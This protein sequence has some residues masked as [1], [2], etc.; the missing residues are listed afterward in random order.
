MGKSLKK[1]VVISGFNIHDDNRGCSALS[2]GAVNFLYKK[3]F[4]SKDHEFINLFPVRKFWKKRNR[5]IYTDTITVDSIEFK[6]KT[7]KYFI[8]EYYL[9]KM[10]S[11]RMPF[12]NFGKVL[13]SILKVAAINGGDGFSDIYGTS[14][15]RHRL[16]ETEIA[17]KQ[18]LPLIILPQTIGPF[19]EQSNYQKAKEILK[20]ADRIFIRDDCF[21]DELRRMDVE[22]ELTKDLSAFMPPDPIDI[23]IAGDSIGINVSGLAYSNNFSGLVGQFEFYPILIDKLIGYYT[24]LGRKVYLIP[25]S[26]NCN[27]PDL[28]NDDFVAC[29]TVADKWKH[30]SNVIFVKKDITAPQIKY[31]ISKMSFFIGTRMHANFAAIYTGVPL[32]GLAYSYKFEG[33]FNANG[34]DGEKQTVM[35]NNITEIEVTQIVK[36]VVDFYEA[37]TSNAK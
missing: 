34:L 36:K 15:F 24:Q 31:V 28:T 18:N 33:A 32:F 11:I 6:C 9:Y 10:F 13:K 22:Y 20:Y 17:M 26:Y 7:I 1:Y 4:V 35:I 3:G 30:N 12:T 5:Q 25:H 19:K 8:G 14:T 2:Y 23:E 37:V 16:Y 29:A 27:N 21:V